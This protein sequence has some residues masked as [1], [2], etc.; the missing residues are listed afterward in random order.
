VFF[1]GQPGA[2]LKTLAA[3]NL[4]FFFDGV[5]A[6]LALTPQEK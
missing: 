1:F 6:N 2:F 5:L 3:A 4:A